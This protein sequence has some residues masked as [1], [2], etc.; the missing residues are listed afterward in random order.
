MENRT[1]ELKMSD[2]NVNTI[3]EIACDDADS[4]LV[5]SHGMQ[6]HSG[7][8][9]RFAEFLNAHRI[10]FAAEDHR[11]HG[12]TALK[13]GGMSALSFLAE[14]DGF[15]RVTQD[16]YEVILYVKQKFKG[17]PVYLFG[18]S[19]G[20]FIAQNLIELHGQD[21]NKAVIC[22]TAGPRRFLIAAAKAAGFAAKSLFGAKK[23][24]VLMNALTF[25]LYNAKIPHPETRFDWLSRDKEAVSSFINDPLCAS[26]A[27]CGFLYDIYSGL[28][29]I[30]RKS[31]IARIPK[32]L[33]VLLISGSE[34]PVGSYSKTVKKLYA[35]YKRQKIKDTRLI[36]YE[37]ARHELLNEINKEEVMND[38][39]AFLKS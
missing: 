7:R 10:A 28:N 39:L 21:I 12:Q 30:H 4:C 1:F 38:V 3:R 26:L 37:G 31:N 27:S 24:S 8:Y 29:Q 5:L 17:K 23:R 22:G 25:G 35:E 2:G 36:L 33:S 13:N 6:E 32:D 19:F 20:S 34:D 16:V 15:N 11:G 9:T 18:H 14:K